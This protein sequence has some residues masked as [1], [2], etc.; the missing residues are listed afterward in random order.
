M[1]SVIILNTLPVSRFEGSRQAEDLMARR[2]QIAGNLP[3]VRVASLKGGRDLGIERA[4]LGT[5]L[6]DELGPALAAI[7]SPMTSSTP[8]NPPDLA[9]KDCVP[10]KGGVPPVKGRKLEGLLRHA[11]GWSALDEH[12]IGRTWLPKLGLA[13]RRFSNAG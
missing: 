1:R 6:I 9:A 10:C 5:K 12:H 3:Q 7:P 13:I 11:L 8:K 4:Y 2:I